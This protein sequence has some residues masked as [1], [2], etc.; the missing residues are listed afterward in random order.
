MAAKILEK[1]S[2]DPVLESLFQSDF[3]R[4]QEAIESVLSCAFSSKKLFEVIL[5]E[6]LAVIKKCQDTALKMVALKNALMALDCLE[7]L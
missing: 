7:E 4:V 5:C 1:A 6:H 2:A 3:S